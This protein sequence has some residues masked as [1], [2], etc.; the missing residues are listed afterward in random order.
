MARTRNDQSGFSITLNIGE[1][2]SEKEGSVGCYHEKNKDTQI[3]EAAQ[4]SLSRELNRV[5]ISIQAEKSGSIDSSY[6][7]TVQIVSFEIYLAKSHVLD[8]VS[9][10]MLTLDSELANRCQ[11]V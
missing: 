6:C 11:S 2:T 8:L 3:I 10:L 1:R 4:P 5:G 7:T 9:T